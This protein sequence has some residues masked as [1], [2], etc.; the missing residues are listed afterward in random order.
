MRTEVAEAGL[1]LLPSRHLHPVRPSPHERTACHKRAPVPP[2][3]S[4]VTHRLVVWRK[5]SGVTLRAFAAVPSGPPHVEARL[6]AL[7]GPARL[8]EGGPLGPVVL[9][10]P[11]L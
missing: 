9:E 11:Q 5:L 8:F 2:Y 10:G 7:G 3:G 4:R 1:P 6:V